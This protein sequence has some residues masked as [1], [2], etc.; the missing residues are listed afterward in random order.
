[1]DAL[2]RV[3]HRLVLWN[4]AT[5]SNGTT[6]VIAIPIGSEPHSKPEGCYGAVKA[7]YVKL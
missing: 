3:F 4:P 1:M 7:F 5:S 6:V 2:L